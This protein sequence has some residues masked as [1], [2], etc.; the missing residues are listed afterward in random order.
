MFHFHFFFLNGQ[1]TQSR[2]LSVP[3]PFLYYISTLLMAYT[4]LSLLALCMLPTFILIIFLKLI[5]RPHPTKIPIKSRHVFITGGSSGIGLALAR[6][7]AAEGALVTILALDY[8]LEEAKTSIKLSTG[9]DVIM[10]KAEVCDFGAVKEADQGV[11][12]A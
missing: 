12:V 7:A 6:Q 9:A 11:F 1:Q 10:L 3:L 4:N 2:A 5:L 8:N